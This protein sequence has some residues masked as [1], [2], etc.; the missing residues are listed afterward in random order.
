[1]DEQVEAL[2]GLGKEEIAQEL[3]ARLEKS[4]REAAEKFYNSVTRLVKAN[5][6]MTAKSEEIRLQLDAVRKYHEERKALLRKLK[7]DLKANKE[8]LRDELEEIKGK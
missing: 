8:N 2:K 5:P 6:S 4:N 7:Q 3:K 1:M